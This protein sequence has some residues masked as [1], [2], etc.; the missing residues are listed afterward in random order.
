MFKQ[1]SNSSVLIA[2]IS[3]DKSEKFYTTDLDSKLKKNFIAEFLSG[4]KLRQ[5]S[6]ISICLS[7]KAKFDQQ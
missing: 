6:K 1:V 4:R 7:G 2:I 5:L 3:Y